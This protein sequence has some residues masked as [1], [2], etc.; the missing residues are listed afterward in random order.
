MRITFRKEKEI[1]LAAVANCGNDNYE[2]KLNGL[3]IGSLS[4]Y[5]MTG[6]HYAINHQDKYFNSYSAG[7]NFKNVDEAKQHCKSWIRENLKNE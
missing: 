5:R 1:R 4:D 3:C 6:I 7:L 2:I